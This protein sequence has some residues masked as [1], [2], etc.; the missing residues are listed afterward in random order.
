MTSEEHK[1]R[2]REQIKDYLNRGGYDRVKGFIRG[3]NIELPTASVEDFT[4][5][6]FRR[7]YTNAGF[8]ER[9]ELETWLYQ[10]SKRVMGDFYR[11]I[12][13]RKLVTMEQ[14][15]VSISDGPYQ[16]HRN[17]EK[18]LLSKEHMELVEK[19]INKLPD[20]HKV[21]ILLYLRGKQKKQIAEEL[22]IAEST[23]GT[24]INRAREI[25]RIMMREAGLKGKEYLTV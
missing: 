23:V 5:D 13:Q 8:D 2:V 18:E 1:E 7:A 11:L 12:N 10:I 22:G 20:H 15:Y 16:P 24:R 14:P 21:T 6:T 4:Q 3:F 25:L 17:L 9:S 19:G